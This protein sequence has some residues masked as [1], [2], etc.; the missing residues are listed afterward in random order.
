MLKQEFL[1]RLKMKLNGLP[2]KE[3]YDRISFYEE[4]IDD[5]I[6]EGKAEET[7]VSEIGTVEEV[8]TQILKDIPL[9]KVI[10]EK[11]KPK[12]NFRVWEIV[13]LALG[14]P[15]WLSLLIAA[16]AVVISLYAVLWSV[17]ITLFALEGALVGCALGGIVAGICIMIGGNL[18]TGTLILAC[19][20]VCAG[21]SVFTVFACKYS[22]KFTIILIRKIFFAIK[23]GLI[24]K[25]NSL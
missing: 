22:V 20:I 15:I 24:K 6:E 9:G 4:M 10:K 23:K 7:A 16:F 17:V 14:S 12:R 2:E 1:D 25:E 5:R 8:A 3:V 19:A 21:L 18:L 13:L 11:I